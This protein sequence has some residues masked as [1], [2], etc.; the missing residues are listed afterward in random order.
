M[1]AMKRDGSS[2]TNLKNRDGSLHD[3]FG[4]ERPIDKLRSRNPVFNSS[5]K[6][7]SNMGTKLP[8]SIKRLQVD[9]IKNN[10]GDI[11]DLSGNYQTDRHFNLKMVGILFTICLKPLHTFSHS[12]FVSFRSKKA[13]TNHS[14]PITSLKTKIMHHRI[15]KSITRPP[16]PKSSTTSMTRAPQSI[17]NPWSSS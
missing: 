3:L 6:T 12:L 7:C 2:L 8:D 5:Y 15:K 9:Y 14:K 17:T 16:P 10:G 4:N 11:N 1:S 13:A